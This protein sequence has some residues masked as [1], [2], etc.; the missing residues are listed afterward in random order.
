[1]PAFPVRHKAPFARAGQEFRVEYTCSELVCGCGEAL[2]GRL[3]PSHGSARPTLPG[4]RTRG[5]LGSRE[6]PDVLTRVLAWRTLSLP[7]S[8]EETSTVPSRYLCWLLFLWPKSHLHS[9]GE[10]EDA[11]FCCSTCN[12]AGITRREPVLEFVSHLGFSLVQG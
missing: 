11:V 2:A 4:L 10:A 6:M 7:P 3:R 1:M 12:F 5:F 8:F 9:H